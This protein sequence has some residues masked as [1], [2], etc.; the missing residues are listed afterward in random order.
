MYIIFVH[1]ERVCISGEISR[2]GIYK[3]S[4]CTCG[5]W[6][7]L[8]A[9]VALWEVILLFTFYQFRWVAAHSVLWHNAWGR[10]IC[11]SRGWLTEQRLWQ[12]HMLHHSPGKVPHGEGEP[13]RGQ[14]GSKGTLLWP[15]SIWHTLL[16]VCMLSD[17]F[18]HDI[19]FMS[20]FTLCCIQLYYPLLSPSQLVLTPP[21]IHSSPHTLMSY[22]CISNVK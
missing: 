13:G 18:H 17:G 11:R 8:N 5:I 1:L 22:V 7:G 21:I 10:T 9:P 6:M 19:A 20:T 15:Q 2:N 3:T 4:M 12:K 14:E 16:L